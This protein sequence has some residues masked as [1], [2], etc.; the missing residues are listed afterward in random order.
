MLGIER[1]RN[2][3]VFFAGYLLQLIIRL[4]VIVHHLLSELLNGV[5][6]SP[7]HSELSQLDLNHAINGGVPEKC[8]IISF[9][10]LHI[11]IRI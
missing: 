8:F 1:I 9:L 2:V 7:L 5:V 6:R 3:D 11:A 4:C 10:N